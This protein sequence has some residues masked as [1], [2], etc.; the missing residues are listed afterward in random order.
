MRRAEA[1]GHAGGNQHGLAQ[2]VGV[3][4]IEHGVVLRNAAG[5]DDAVHRHAVL[6]HALQD[7]ARVK[8]RAL[9]GREK[10]VLRGVHQIPAEGD[11]AQFGIDQ[12]GAVAVVPGEAQQAGLSGL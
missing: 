9:D 12:H 2:H 3:D 10:L 8:G 5:V 1:G 4:L 6:G 11:A 7:N